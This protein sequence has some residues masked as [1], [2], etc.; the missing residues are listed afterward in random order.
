MKIKMPIL[1]NDK[2]VKL[3]IP[4]KFVARV[5]SLA[6]SLIV[7]K[8]KEEVEEAYRKMQTSEPAA[9]EFEYNMQTVHALIFEIES[10]AKKQNL[11]VDKEFEIDPKDLNEEALR[12]L[13]EK[14]NVI[15]S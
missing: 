4:G 3:E 9:N 11:Y 14:A 15:E 10:Q 12:T 6:F 2:I 13:K 1:E 8:S 5:Q 7:N